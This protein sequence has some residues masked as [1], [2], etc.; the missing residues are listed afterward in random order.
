MIMISKFGAHDERNHKLSFLEYA[1]V[2]DRFRSDSMENLHEP[3]EF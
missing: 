3:G 1:A 2:L